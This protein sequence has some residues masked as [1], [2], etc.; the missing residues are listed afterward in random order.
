MI[1]ST[2][3]AIPDRNFEIRGLVL[4]EG[5]VGIGKGPKSVDMSMQEIAQQAA[6]LG[7]NAVVDV[8]VIRLSD[9]RWVVTGTAVVIKG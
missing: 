7:A 4:A 6:Q 2:L 3:P 1:L 8:K 5:F 9:A